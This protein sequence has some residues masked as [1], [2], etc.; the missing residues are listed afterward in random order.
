MGCADTY[1]IPWPSSPMGEEGQEAIS[2]VFDT[3]RTHNIISSV[4]FW[5]RGLAV[6]RA[7]A[8]VRKSGGKFLCDI[9]A[10]VRGLAQEH[11]KYRA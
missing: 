10:H 6:C 3:T 11:V 4:G 8:K 9:P 2:T 5:G 7:F 1:L